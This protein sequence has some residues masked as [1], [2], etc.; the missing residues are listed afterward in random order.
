LTEQQRKDLAWTRLDSLEGYQALVDS[1]KKKIQKTG[2]SSL[3]EWELDE[4]G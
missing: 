1:G 2:D 3:S 4:T